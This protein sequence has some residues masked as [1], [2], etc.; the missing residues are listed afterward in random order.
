MGALAQLSPAILSQ[1]IT[2]LSPEQLQALGLRRPATDQEAAAYDQAHQAPGAPAD[3]G[4]SVFPNPNGIKVSD[5]TDSGVEPMRLPNGLS[6]Q[7]SNWHGQTPFDASNPPA[8]EMAGPALHTVQAQSSPDASAWKPVDE[9][10]WKP[11]EETKTAPAQPATKAAEPPGFWE[12][13]SR[14]GKALEG[15]IEGVPAAVYHA[16]NEPATKEEADK[17]G[18]PQEVTG[19]KRIGLGLHR[20]TTAPVETAANWYSDAAKGKI[21]DPYGQALTVMPEAL[22]SAGG[23]MLAGKATELAPEAAQGA[24]RATANAIKETA[25][26]PAGKAAIAATKAAAKELPVAAVRRIPYVGKVAADVYRA[27]SK[28]A[29]E[30]K[31]AAPAEVPETATPAEPAKPAP[32][33][34][35]LQG[36]VNDALGGKPLQKGIPLRQQMSAAPQAAK[37]PTDFTPVESSALRGYKYDPQAQEFSAITKNGQKYTHGEVTPEQAAEFEA[38]DSKG[39]AWNKIR[40]NNVLVRQND[41]PVKPSTMQAPSGQIVPKAQA[42]NLAEITNQPPAKAMETPTGDL[43]DI[44]QKSLEKVQAGK[45]KLPEGAPR[46]VY[47]ARDVGEE[48]VPLQPNSHAQATSDVGQALKYAE[49]GQRGAEAGQVVRIDLSKLKPSDYVVQAHPNGMK[50]VKFTRPLSETEV[51]HFAGQAAGKVEK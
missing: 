27:G 16:F 10:A 28:A 24:A 21:P 40:E 51:S 31:E 30:A 3:F 41:L 14:E 33:L 12:T 39:Q 32:T 44:L 26:S 17:F 37:L 9:S 13:L 11:V 5:D 7:G 19:A 35:D 49:P 15:S 8:A 20:L 6:L 4:G 43:T 25:A 1:L 36:A 34:K 22:G 50:W 48:G 18:G 29:A 45:G 42:G 38:S 23:S 47:R 2:Q 46:F